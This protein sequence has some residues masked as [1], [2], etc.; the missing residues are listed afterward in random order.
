MT[1]AELRSNCKNQPMIVSV[2]RDIAAAP[3]AGRALEHAD[4]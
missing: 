1:R 2:S 4:A 3:D